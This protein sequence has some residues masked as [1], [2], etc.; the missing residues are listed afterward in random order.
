MRGI[1]V[2]SLPIP[3]FGRLS[4]AIIS[5]GF[6][7]AVLASY[8]LSGLYY[9]VMDLRY[10]NVIDWYVIGEARVGLAVLC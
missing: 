8:L 6:S 4:T 2:G 9:R 5:E 1:E 3:R 7:K 10:G